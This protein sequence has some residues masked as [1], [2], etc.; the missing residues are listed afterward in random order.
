MDY[1]DLPPKCTSNS[2]F[3]FK[4]NKNHLLIKLGCCTKCLLS[5]QPDFQTQKCE[6]KKSNQN[7][8]QGQYHIVLYYPKFYFKLN[9]IEHFW[10]SAKQYA[11]FWYKY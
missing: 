6:I 10:C 2:L 1:E 8:P 7:S 11:R 5:V 3:F 9:H 4:F